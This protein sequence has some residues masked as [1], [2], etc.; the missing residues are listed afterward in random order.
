[1]GDLE[2]RAE[3]SEA[4]A[5]QVEAM[6]TLLKSEAAKVKQAVVMVDEKV[7]GMQAEIHQLRH[8][9]AQYEPQAM[10]AQQGLAPS[11]PDPLPMVPSSVLELLESLPDPVIAPP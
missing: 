6:E 1:M 5:K 4:R 10:L 9:L 7:E 8:R 3:Q 2:L 11:P